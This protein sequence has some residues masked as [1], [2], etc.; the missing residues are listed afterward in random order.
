MFAREGSLAETILIEDQG[1]WLEVTLNRPNKLNCFDDDMHIALRRAL[2]QAIS[3]EKRAI[4]ITGAG[5]GFCAGQDLG[6]RDPSKLDCPPDL[7]Q[8]LTTFYN[9][10][11]RLI[12]DAEMPVICAVNGV[13]A[14]AG[15]NLALACDIVLAAE[16]AE[17]I[18]SFAHVGL[19]PDAGGTWNLTR[20]LGP[21]RAK[22]LAITGEPVLAPQAAEWGMIWKAVPN[23]EL[24]VEARALAA[25]LA[26]GPTFGFAHVKKAINAAGKTSFEDQLELEARY[27]QACGASADYAEGV[28]AFLNKRTPEFQGK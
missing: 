3:D 21:A 14:G 22:A 20:L 19:I 23:D 28:T 6:D 11:I 25:R 13:A 9:P 4:L 5:R 12:R 15:A 2:E 16:T 24:L 17:F 18:Q 1:N 10:L 27:Q 7:S 8:T 26:N